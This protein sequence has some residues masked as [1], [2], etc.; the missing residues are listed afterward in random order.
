[1]AKVKFQILTV[2][3]QEGLPGTDVVS[4]PRVLDL[5]TL[6]LEDKIIIPVVKAL[7]GQAGTDEKI[8]AWK[9]EHG[10]DGWMLCHEEAG[11]SKRSFGAISAD[12]APETKVTRK[13]DKK[14]KEEPGDDE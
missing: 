3:E 9:K 13:R 4:R 10:I 1:M 7:K 8:Q 6:N 5:G 14:E 12:E 11:S 2:D